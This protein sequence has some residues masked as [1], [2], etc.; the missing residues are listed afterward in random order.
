LAVPDQNSSDEMSAGSYGRSA[1]VMAG[2]LIG[3]P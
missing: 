1:R 2:A 3:S